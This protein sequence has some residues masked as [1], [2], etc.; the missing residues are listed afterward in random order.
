MQLIILTNDPSLTAWGWAVIKNDRI[1]DSGCIKTSP[2]HKK[3]RIRKSDDT[4]RR[5]SDINA[6]LLGVI[7]KHK[8]NYILSE[9]PHGSQNA[10][11]ATMIG[12]AA[13]ITQTISDCLKIGIEYFSEQDSKKT[14]LGKKAATKNE[15]VEAISK[16]YPQR[17]IT[18][19]FV[20]DIK[21]R[22]EAVADAIAVYHTAK[23]L[24]T[25]LK[26]LIQSEQDFS[27]IV[28][29]KA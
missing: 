5:I 15:M 17:K 23:K 26:T 11:A 16:L 3:Q 22:D 21:F 25:T 20:T 28:Y 19:R 14:V 24:S 13:G 12:I 8:V 27:D 18:N 29:S 1:I 9:A 4:T 7:Q 6:V 10:S 2:E